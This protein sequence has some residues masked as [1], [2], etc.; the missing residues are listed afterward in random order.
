MTGLPGDRPR[1]L[2]CMGSKNPSDPDA[3]DPVPSNP[4]M[5]DPE[6]TAVSGDLVRQFW[7]KAMELERRLKSRERL[8]PTEREH[9]LRGLF[10]LNE[11]MRRI[12]KGKR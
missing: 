6:L 11:L 9:I 10:E 12:E 5:R 4:A 7:N 2:L 1:E 3:E 8:E